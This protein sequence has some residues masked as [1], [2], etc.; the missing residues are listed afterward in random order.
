MVELERDGIAVRIHFV[1]FCRSAIFL[2]LGC[3]YLH[4]KIA[5]MAALPLPQSQSLPQ[6]ASTILICPIVENNYNETNFHSLAEEES[7]TSYPF[8]R[9]DPSRSHTHALS[10]SLSD[11]PPQG[12][13]NKWLR[14]PLLFSPRGC[15]VKH[16]VPLCVCVCG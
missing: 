5:K 3:V 16:F 6:P 2:T 4:G 13:C 11:P 9:T 15:G 7:K 12:K 8:G 1:L 10:P 14:L